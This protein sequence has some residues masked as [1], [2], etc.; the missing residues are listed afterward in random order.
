VAVGIGTGQPAVV[1][2]G[3]LLIVF[4]AVLR[5]T[6]VGQVLESSLPA[7][8]TPKDP[9]RPH[10]GMGAEVAQGAVI[11]PGATVEMGAEVREGAVVKSG[12][13]VRMG[14]TVKANAVLEEGATV[15]W[16]ADVEEGA[17]VGKGAVVGAGATVR[18][19]AHVPAGTHM[20]PGSTWSAGTGVRAE[21]KQAAPAPVQDPREARIL[22]ACERIET[23]L[24]QAPEAARELLGASAETAL[25]LRET[26]LG[27]LRR[28]RTLRLESSPESLAFLDKEKAELHRRIMGTAD[29]AV[30]QSLTQA[31]AAIEE[32]R[33]QRGLM[34]QSAERLDAELTRLMWTLDSMG[35]QLARL[36]AAGTE[37]TSATDPEML[38]SMQQ[39]HDEI[40][41]ITEALEGVARGDLQPVSP[42]DS[43][44]ATPGGS[45]ARERT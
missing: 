34:H 32:Q 45:R 20:M 30:R 16:G 4:G 24:R 5:L 44:G 37:A 28:E 8:L 40:D 35:A 22:A 38:R 42:V 27:L 19:G 41:A 2:I 21:P 36:R 43:G 1:V 11:E 7:G 33:R 3:A 26:C 12:A 15:G 39:L 18:K 10:I 6:G 17:V 29:V 14:A 31:V 25:G 23:E 13:V 9:T